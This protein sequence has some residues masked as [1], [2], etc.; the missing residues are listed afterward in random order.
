MDNLE[1]QIEKIES[2]IHAQKFLLME[3][4]HAFN[5]YKIPPKFLYLTL[6][7]GFIFGFWVSKKIFPSNTPIKKDPDLISKSK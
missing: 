1:E 2:E 5:N 4:Y 6:L 3:R 7:C